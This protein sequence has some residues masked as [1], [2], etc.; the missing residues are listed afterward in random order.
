[1]VFQL[2]SFDYPL[3]ILSRGFYFYPAIFYLCVNYPLFIIHYPLSIVNY[4]LSIVNYPL[5][6]NVRNTYSTQNEV[7]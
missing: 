2:K 4:P 3:S 6:K 7:A 5:R 1:M